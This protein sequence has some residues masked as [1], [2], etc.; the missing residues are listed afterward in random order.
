MRD[1]IPTKKTDSSPMSFIKGILDLT[2]REWIEFRVE[3]NVNAKMTRKNRITDFNSLK[4]VLH[5][6]LGK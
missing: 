2:T 4:L 6:L 1:I 3:L 5:M